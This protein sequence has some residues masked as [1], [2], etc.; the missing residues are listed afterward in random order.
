MKKFLAL[1]L[2]LIMVVSLAA[3]GGET[4]PTDPATDPT[5]APTTEPT[6]AG[7][8]EPT[9]APTEPEETEPTEPPYVTVE[10]TGNAGE[11]TYNSAWSVF[12]TLWNPHTYET[13]TSADVM[14][15]IEDGFY[16]FDY[17]DDMTGFQFVNSMATGDPID[18]TAD[19]VGQW[20]IE[21][22]D[23]ALVYKIVLRDD[24]YWETGE[25]ITATD[26]VESAKRLL[27]PIAQNYR[28][29]TMYTGD[30]VIYN[31]EAY[32]KQGQ[33]A[34]VDNATLE[35]ANLVKGEDGVYT[36]AEGDVCYV[37][38]GTPI[39]YF[40]N[41][42]SLTDYVDAYGESYFDISRWEE[43]VALADDEGLVAL[44]DESYEMLKTT[45]TG[46]PAWGEDESY[47]CNYLIYK[48]AFP[49]MD[50]SEVGIFA[51]SDTELV[52]VLT[53]PMEGFY[54]KYGMPSGYLV[55]TATYDACE[56]VDENGLY[57]NTYGT[58]LESTVSYGP[59]KMVE[60]QTD[61]IFKFAKNEYWYGHEDGYYQTTHIEVQK[62]DSA[63]TRLNML[64]N[65]VLDTYGLQKDDF[66]TYSLSD[67][68]YYA[69]GAS[70]YAMVFNPDMD[71]LTTSQE[72]AGENINKTILTVK[73]FR[74]GMALGLNRAEFILATS[75]AGSPAFGLFSTQHIVDPDSGTGYRTTE[76]AKQTLAEFWGVAGDIGE[77][78]LYE[79]LDEAVDSLTGYNPDLAKQK[80][81]QA[82]D[83]AI[84]AGI[85]DE[86]DVVEI[87]IGLPSTSPTYTN[88]YEFIVNNFTE[89]VKGT[90]LEGKLTFTRDDT[91]AD[92]FAGSLQSNQV[93]MLFYVGWSGMELNPYG[94]MQAY[95]S[96][97]YQYDS[98]MDYTT[99]DLTIELDGTAW[100]TTVYNWY[101]IMN[102][103]AHTITD[104]EGNTKEFSCGT[105]DKDPETRLQILGELE[106]AILLNYTYIPLSGA[107]SAQLKGMQI[108]YN[109]EEYIFGMGFGGIKYMTYNYDDAEW[110]AFV[111]GQNG[112][113]DYT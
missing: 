59:Y 32:L 12:P 103:A 75:P 77:G 1:L 95:V 30:V 106:R 98:H 81:Q 61:K 60:Y 112:E 93:D 70:V 14:A 74:E 109:T 51:L 91:I 94:L 72:A 20:G 45:I 68:C 21:E 100:T 76:I 89:L 97:N 73:A 10:V 2:A 88:G 69:E 65:G 102:G 8:D 23:K 107:A 19:Y 105:A 26:Y 27:N 96:S 82:Y 40:S 16:S 99:V 54:L 4:T 55:H 67:Y 39:A 35:L 104:A 50:F 46:N 52:Y 44:T 13:A 92:N 37:A 90:S 110:A 28:A 17:N 84:S 42:N 66:A 111:N 31:A 7:G 78:K 6:T 108:N 79:T 56:S 33:V 24:L 113:L 36:T 43:L 80:F 34:N 22:G 63:T 18:I 3:C 5:N 47:L 62:V 41:K 25:K 9:D 57:S 11:Y 53:T 38:V 83:E 64:I 71:A 15:Y 86:D 87:C 29:D 101:E 58:S 48:H 49:E 85:M